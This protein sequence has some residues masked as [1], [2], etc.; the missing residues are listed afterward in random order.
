MQTDAQCGEAQSDPDGA[1]SKIEGLVPPNHALLEAIYIYPIKSCAP[2][3]AGA[4]LPHRRLVKPPSSVPPEVV[5][6]SGLGTNERP[7]W[8]LGPS[9][10]A[11]DRE[12]A[13]VDHRNRALRLKQVRACVWFVRFQFSLVINRVRVIA[14]VCVCVCVFI[15]LHITA[16][17]GLVIL[18]ILC[19]SH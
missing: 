11:Y 12:W 2:Q 19:H 1:A 3:R 6:N 17:S 15:K 7:V 9:G 5:E 13:L 4:S 14:F 16:Q 8:P 18:V 10:L